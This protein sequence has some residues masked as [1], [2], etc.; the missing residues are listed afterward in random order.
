MLM[1]EPSP[2][3]LPST[4]YSALSAP[5]SLKRVFILIHYFVYDEMLEI[6]GKGEIRSLQ[7]GVQ[8][9]KLVLRWDFGF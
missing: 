4:F 3:I 5:C 8:K 9:V 1:G 7:F 6:M 2:G